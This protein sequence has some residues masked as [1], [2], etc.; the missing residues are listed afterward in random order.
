MFVRCKDYKWS[1]FEEKPILI[2]NNI[3]S[4]IK[5][6]F[7]PKIIIFNNSMHAYIHIQ[8]TTYVKKKITTQKLK[9]I[10]TEWINFWTILF[11]CSKSDSTCKKKHNMWRRKLGE[12]IVTSEVHKFLI[13]YWVGSST[14]AL[15]CS[16]TTEFLPP[17]PAVSIWTRMQSMA[18]TLSLLKLPILPSRARQAASKPVPLPSISAKLN[19]QKD[20]P[21]PQKFLDQNVNALK[22]T[23]LTLTA[24]TFPLLL[25]PKASTYSRY[26][27]SWLLFIF[28]RRWVLFLSHESVIG[29]H[30]M[31]LLLVES[32]GY[33]REE[34]L[35]SYT[36]L[37]WVLCSSIPS[38]QGIWGGNGGEWGLSRMRSMNS[39]NKSSLPQSP[40]MGNRWKHHRHR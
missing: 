22:H 24:I 3:I 33:W 30:R 20:F 31:H 34:H 11:T 6:I 28:W 35:L 27:N 5:K 1:F 10:K 19:T 16:C 39:R 26:M 23:S 40:P 15:Y 21:N 9:W 37:C 18:A 12:R 8:M 17:H 2:K 13:F 14:L 36:P 25:E 4:E 38:M 32:L 7:K 29:C